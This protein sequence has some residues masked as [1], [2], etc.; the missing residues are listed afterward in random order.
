[1]PPLPPGDAVV[2]RTG[3][4]NITISTARVDHV[5]AVEGHGE[6]R[7]T[8][9]PQ[10]FVVPA[11]IEVVVYQG[12]GAGLDDGH[13]VTIGQLGSLPSRIPT[14]YDAGSHEYDTAAA[15]SVRA[16]TVGVRVYRAGELCP[17]LTL[18]AF[19]EPGYPPITPPQPGSYGAVAG[20]PEPL[21]DIAGRF[22]ARGGSWQLRWG[23]CTVERS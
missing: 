12:T 6:M 20:A 9:V 17:N 7:A 13:G 15:G 1:M 2:Q 19:D 3:T 21:K 5:V 8:T 11:G 18:L 4:R 10:R 14:E 23:A 16:N 22:L